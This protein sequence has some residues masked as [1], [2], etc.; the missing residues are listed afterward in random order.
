M[1]IR[2]ALVNFLVGIRFSHYCLHAEIKII[3]CTNINCDEMLSILSR[4]PTLICRQIVVWR[5]Q[6]LGS[7]R[8]KN[9]TS[10]TYMIIY[11]FKWK[12]PIYRWF[13]PTLS[14]N[15]IEDEWIWQ[16]SFRGKHF[17]VLILLYIRDNILLYDV[18]NVTRIFFSDSLFIKISWFYETT[19][20]TVPDPC[21]IYT[22][23]LFSMSFC[24]GDIKR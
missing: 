17:I 1:K 11:A 12:I 16:W 6:L 15:K 22:L 19:V 5:F 14:E 21:L 13:F 2:E 3:Q 24:L 9:R 23:L 18:C 20:C 10:A 4:F 8:S 7:G